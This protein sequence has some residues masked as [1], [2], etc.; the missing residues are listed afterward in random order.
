M[1]YTAVHMPRK[2][3]IL[4]I[5]AQLVEIGDHFHLLHLTFSRSNEVVESIVLL[6]AH[7]IE[8][9]VMVVRVSKHDKNSI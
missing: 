8:S 3:V 4:S 9:E 2:C 1:N 6:H 7:A 5:Q